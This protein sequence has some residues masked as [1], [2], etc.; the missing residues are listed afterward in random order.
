MQSVV[1]AGRYTIEG[2]G[3]RM[4]PEAR[5]FVRSAVARAL[6]SAARELELSGVSV[7]VTLDAFEVHDI[8]DLDIPEQHRGHEW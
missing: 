8:K 7:E 1:A 3:Q 5:S 6:E 2:T 4:T